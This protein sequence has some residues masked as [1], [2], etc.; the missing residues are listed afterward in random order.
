[1][2]GTVLVSALLL[3]PLGPPAAG[4]NWHSYYPLW[5]GNTSEMRASSDKGRPNL[6]SIEV[7][8]IEEVKGVKL[9]RTQT[10]IDGKPSGAYE[11]LRVTKEGVFRHWVSGV[12]VDP[13]YCVLK[14]PIKTGDSWTVDS[15]LHDQAYK[16]SVRVLRPER[17][18][19]PAGVYTAVPVEMVSLPGATHQ[20]ETTMWFAE[21][22][23]IVKLVTDIGGSKV[24][25]ELT[26]FT[27]GKIA[28]PIVRVP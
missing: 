16:F 4:K 24:V 8:A 25:L 28:V 3:W 5:I 19:V 23:G 9:I 26:K 15:K 22:V 7:V 18:A 13:P 12:R 10:A 11:Y 2:S 21:K 6:L 17:V 14:Y 1:M 27:P 20:I